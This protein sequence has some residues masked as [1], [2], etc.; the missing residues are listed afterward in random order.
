M[1][2]ERDLG[3]LAFADQERGFGAVVGRHY[4]LIFQ[5]TN[6]L[7]HQI[8]ERARMDNIVM[9][10]RIIHQQATPARPLERGAGG[11]KRAHTQGG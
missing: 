1:H 7:A 3:A 11:E 8:H 5:T 2:D 9:L 6:E 4:H 10:Q